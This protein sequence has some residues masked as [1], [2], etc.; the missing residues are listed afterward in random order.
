MGE[1]A[2][3][4]L[5]ILERLYRD[6]SLAHYPT[7]V[8]ET[9]RSHVR[10]P[11]GRPQIVLGRPSLR[12]AFEQGFEEYPALARL[13]DYRRPAGL[14][15]VRQLCLHE[16]AHVL[17]HRDG[18]LSLRAVHNGCFVAH[19]VALMLKY[20]LNSDGPGASEGYG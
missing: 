9:R 18:G 12:R 11:D 8:D 19:Y 10:F 6:H 7:L 3:Y 5:D 2:W 1:P 20:P 15:G 4:A 14:A 16:F 13:L 17:Q